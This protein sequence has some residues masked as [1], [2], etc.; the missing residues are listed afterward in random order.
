MIKLVEYKVRHVINKQMESKM[1]EIERE[2]EGKIKKW[3]RDF[4]HYKVACSQESRKM[5]S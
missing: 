2:Y 5:V 3:N 4:V 1:D